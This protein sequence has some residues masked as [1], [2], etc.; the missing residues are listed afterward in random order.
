MLVVMSVRASAFGANDRRDGFTTHARLSFGSPTTRDVIRKQL[1][2]LP[3]EAAYK[4][5][6]NQRDL[7]SATIQAAPEVCQF[8]CV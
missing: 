5:Q 6:P 1:W 7:K 4:H 2:R 8:F 3:E